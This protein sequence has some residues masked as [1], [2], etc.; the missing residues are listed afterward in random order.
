MKTGFSEMKAYLDVTIPVA[1]ERVVD[2]RFDRL[3]GLLNRFL[4]TSGGSGGAKA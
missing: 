1:V 3:E 4:G 2:S